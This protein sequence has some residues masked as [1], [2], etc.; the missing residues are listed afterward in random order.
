MDRDKAKMQMQLS[1]DE[2]NHKINYYRLNLERGFELM[3]LD[4]WR[5]PGPLKPK[6]GSIISNRIER[7]SKVVPRQS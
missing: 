7:P 3:E 2:P 5:A 1:Q 4:E 6:V